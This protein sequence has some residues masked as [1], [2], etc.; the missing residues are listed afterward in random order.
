M[1][2]LIG[3]ILAASAQTVIRPKISCPN[4]IYVNSYNGDLFYQ[5]V[6]LQIPNRGLNLEAVF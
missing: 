5:R 3:S 1:A 2:L 6:D 4:G